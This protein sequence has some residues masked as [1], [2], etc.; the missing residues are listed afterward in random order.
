MPM[1]T[2]RDLTPFAELLA[3]EQLRRL[4]AQGFSVELHMPNYRVSV[5]L[6]NKFARVDIGSSGRYMVDLAT[7]EIFGVKAYGVVHRGHRF[8]TLDTIAEWSWGDYRAVRIPAAAKTETKGPDLAPLVAALQG[9]KDNIRVADEGGAASNIVPA[10]LEPSDEAMTLIRNGSGV[11]STA[12]NRFQFQ[13]GNEMDPTDPDA[14]WYAIDLAAGLPPT[15]IAG[16]FASLEGAH[17]HILNSQ[18]V[19]V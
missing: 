19:L 5:K 13:N 2:L 4:E 12:D 18:R 15:E 1:I 10:G 8:G 3:R 6:G 7:G 9:V 17:E 14:S 16:P 11:Y